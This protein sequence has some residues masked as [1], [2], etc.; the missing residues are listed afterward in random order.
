MSVNCSIE[1]IWEIPYEHIN[2]KRKHTPP[3]RGQSLE[4][5]QKKAISKISSSWLWVDKTVLLSVLGVGK[6]V[7]LRE[8][9]FHGQRLSESQLPSGDEAVT[10]Y[11]DLGGSLTLFPRFGADPLANDATLQAE[12]EQHFDSVTDFEAV[13][14]D[15]VNGNPIPYEN[16]ILRYANMTMQL[17]A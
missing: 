8:N 9:N 13:F 17:V 10:L 3:L 7:Q 6:P 15:L 11:E 4:G 1:K 14:G 5:S 2:K 16:A 12:R